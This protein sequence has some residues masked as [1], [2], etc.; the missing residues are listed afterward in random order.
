M[1]FTGG[2]RR[3][4]ERSGLKFELCILK[5]S[6]GPPDMMSTHFSDFLTPSPSTFGIDLYN[7]I[8]ATSL[9]TSAFP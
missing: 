8:H 2:T 5:Y 3:E 6:K 4:K 1:G 7:K 9:T